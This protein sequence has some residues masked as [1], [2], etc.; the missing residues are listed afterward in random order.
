ML[1]GRMKNLVVL[2]GVVVY[3]FS[4]CFSLADLVIC[5]GV[6]GHVKIETASNHCS[7]HLPDC[8]SEHSSEELAFSENDCGSCLDI[9]LAT[10]KTDPSLFSKTFRSVQIQPV[11]AGVFEYPGSNSS[12][13][14]INSSFSGES[15]PS[16]NIIKTTVLLI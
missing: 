16:L 8:H 15:N 2:V 10:G 5:Y 11:S 12:A 3:G 6:D 1:S 14:I 4:A 7:G 9:P 13:S